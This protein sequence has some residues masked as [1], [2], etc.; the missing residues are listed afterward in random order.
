MPDNTSPL[1]L[2]SALYELSRARD[3]ARSQLHFSSKNTSS[4]NTTPKPGAREGLVALER[5]VGHGLEKATDRAIRRAR[6]LAR[7]AADFVVRHTPI[8][9]SLTQPVRNIMTVHVSACSPSDS[10]HRAAQLLWDTNCGSVP[11]M[12]PGGKLVGMLTDRDI[13]MASF[14]QSRP[15][16]ATQVDSAMSRV[17][18]TC[19]PTDSIL[20]AMDIMSV[21]QVRRVP[22]VHENGKLAG[23]VALA[24]IA[25][26]V[27][28]LPGKD[29]GAYVPLGMTLSAISEKRGDPLSSVR[30]AE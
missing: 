9:S 18:Y 7:G 27:Q 10:L 25:R 4:S 21:R 14:T 17:V 2:K 6:Q 8:A 15:L 19:A 20:R 22:I 30:A 1:T 3:A 24:D 12:D 11:V 28:S 23:I 26:Y 16:S 13:C 29:V 5:N